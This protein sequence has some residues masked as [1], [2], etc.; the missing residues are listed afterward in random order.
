MLSLANVKGASD[1]PVSALINHLVDA[2]YDTYDNRKVIHSNTHTYSMFHYRASESQ[3]AAAAG[4]AL[5]STSGSVTGGSGT[6]N[7][8]RRSTDASFTGSSLR[9]SGTGSGSGAGGYWLGGTGRTESGSGA[10]GTG[11]AGFYGGQP[12]APYSGGP[13]PQPDWGGVASGRSLAASSRATSAL[14]SGGG[15]GGGSVCFSTAGG[16]GCMPVGGSELEVV[17]LYDANFQAANARGQH[18]VPLRVPAPAHIG[19]LSY[20]Y[21]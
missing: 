18:G 8:T 15:G 13:P 14:S 9:F 10:S 20:V 21:R 4:P 7:F 6:G 17:A 5:G 19:P 2:N 16:A 11:S 3:A 12:I 1:R